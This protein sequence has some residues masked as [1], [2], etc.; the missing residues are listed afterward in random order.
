MYLQN[1]GETFVTF[2]LTTQNW[3]P[4]NAQNY[5]QL[6]WNYDGTPIGPGEVVRIT[7]SLDVSPTISGINNFNFDIVILG[8]VL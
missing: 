1:N 6:S 4:S 3:V 8:T 5:L 7:M 2:T